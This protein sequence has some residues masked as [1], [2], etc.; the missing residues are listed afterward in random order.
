MQISMASSAASLHGGV[1]KEYATKAIHEL[2]SAF[3]GEVA[4]ADVTGLAEKTESSFK[5]AAV[6]AGGSSGDFAYGSL[7]S[8]IIAR[9]RLADDV[10]EVLEAGKTGKTLTATLKAWL[11]SKEDRASCAKALEFADQWLVREGAFEA[12]IDGL[13]RRR[14]L[15]PKL[16]NWIVVPDGWDIGTDL[17]GIHSVLASS[18]DIN[19]LVLC[20]DPDPSAAFK[21]SEGAASAAL[22]HS[23]HAHAHTAQPRKD[24][25]LYALNYGTAYVAS[26]SPAVDPAQFSKALAEA[27]AFKGP[28]IVLA[29]IPA[30]PSASA[31]AGAHASASPS[32]PVRHFASSLSS[33]DKPSVPAYL[34]RL[35]EAKES[36]SEDGVGAHG[37]AHAIAVA[38]EAVEAGRWP[39]YR[40]DPSLVP[41]EAEGHAVGGE[42][43]NPADGVPQ[44]RV[45]SA[46][47]RADLASFLDR[48][49]SLA[50]LAR[51]E[52]ALHPALTHSLEAHATA[53]TAAAAS[54]LKAQFE[55]LMGALTKPPLLVLFGSD[56][57]NAEAVARR[58]ASEAR[59]RGYSEVTCKAMDAVAPT[60]LATAPL[61]VFV[62]STA[63]QGEMPQNA[64]NF[65]KGLTSHAVHLANLSFA[66]FGL[67]DS[68]YWPRK[69]QR[70][71]FNKASVDLDATL[72][73]LGAARLVERG[74]GDDQSVGGYNADF[75][76]WVPALWQALGVGSPTDDGSE[77]APKVRGNEAI[78]ATSNGLRGTI[79]QGLLDTSTGAISYEDGQ[80]T[81]FHGIYQQDDR[82]A[83][84]DRKK[85]GLEPA[86][87]FM[88]RVRVPGGVA[89]PAQYLALDAIADSHANGTLRVTTRQAIQFHGIIKG[90]LKPAIAGINKS[91]MD[92]LAACGDVNRN[93]MCALPYEGEGTTLHAKVLEFSRKLSDYLS[94]RTTAYAEIWLDDKLVKSSESDVEVCTACSHPL[95][96]YPPPHVSRCAYPSAAHLRTHLSTTQVQ[97]RCRCAAQQ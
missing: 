50:L 25:G 64:R 97:D 53:Q 89:T 63:G 10:S 81:K 59:A 84:A 90:K 91:L 1:A 31:H 96:P 72:A 77:G 48:E 58:V 21:S 78:K 23:P 94:P 74:V 93:V 62:V 30:Q 9:Q 55:A 24:I 14:S 35:E 40:W 61:A 5:P 17:S 38:R 68:N 42:V 16:S 69:E 65:Y 76:A 67:G 47:V 34:Y 75:R 4:L 43:V 82:D 3:R 39:L 12:S 41:T 49:R 32:T 45:D 70:I 92:T 73:S 52:P 20:S 11:A 54:A 13:Y 56:G 51:T 86:Y 60:T 57:G 29:Y 36:K 44:F 66:V 26:T 79:A 28:S 71:F 85:A 19:V 33:P 6:V 80:L 22:T 18:E 8:R 46:K 15:L 7:L 88:V 37:G 83:R 27:D 2:L 87:S 95:L